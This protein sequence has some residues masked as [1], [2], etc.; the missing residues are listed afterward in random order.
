[1]RIRYPIFA[2]FVLVVALT[3]CDSGPNGE[4]DA[5]SFSTAPSSALTDVVQNTPSDFTWGLYNDNVTVQLESGTDWDGEIV[6]EAFQ[7]Q[8]GEVVNQVTTEP[9]AA[10]DLAAGTS[11]EALY[12]DTRWIP[13]SQWVP[14]D[15]WAPTSQWI[16]GSQW[17]PATIEDEAQSQVDLND[18]ETMVVVF[19]RAAAPDDREVTARPFGLVFQ[20]SGEGTAELVTTT[21]GV[22]DGYTASVDGGS[23]TAIGLADTAYVS[24]LSSGSHQATLSGLDGPCSVD[25]STPRSFNI[26]AGDTSTVTFNVTCGS[27]L[28]D[29]ITFFSGRD[30]PG[31]EI[32]AMAA[33]GS[34]VQRLTNN[35]ANFDGYPAV[36]PNGHQVAFAQATASGQFLTIMNPDGSN[37]QSVTE[38]S[39]DPGFYTWSP[40]NTALAFDFLENGSYDVY[41]VNRDGTG[42]TALTS[43]SADDRNPTWGPDG[44]IAFVSTRN[45]GDYEIYTMDADGSNVQQITSGADLP[46]YAP[47]PRF[48][49]DGSRIAFL[50]DRDGNLNVY[51]IAADGSDVQQVTDDPASDRFPTWSPDG[52]TIAFERDSEIYTIS[53]DGSGTPQNLTQNSDLDGAP[54]WSPVQ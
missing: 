6:L 12:P 40:D 35:S 37:V 30:D 22:D 39:T 7:V 34:N 4:P 45:G 26:S 48:S 14:G 27:P 47:S 31:Y 29:Q 38:A 11:T 13:G 18:D 21:A 1:M 10:S 25:G 50:S 49:P 5:L 2:L 54:F 28:S 41:K 9:V 33:D 46:S 53:A 23:G 43:S 44:T 15:Q 36:A 24:G 19:A 52:S 51:T 8:N 32:Y 42:R 17:A 20:Q 3:A 16:P